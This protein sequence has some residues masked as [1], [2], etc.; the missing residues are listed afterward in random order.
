MNTHETTIYKWKEMGRKE[1][2][3]ILSQMPLRERLE[4][5]QDAPET[6]TPYSY[7]IKKS[8]AELMQWYMNAQCTRSCGG[9]FKGQMNDEFVK[10]YTLLMEKYDV[11]TPSKEVSYILGEFNGAGSF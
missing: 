11:P 1:A 10:E 2:N 6:M 3:E 5:L 7:W 8:K 4:S 9:H